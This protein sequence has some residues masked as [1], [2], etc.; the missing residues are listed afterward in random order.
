MKTFKFDR[1]EEMTSETRKAILDLITDVE[2][3]RSTSDNAEL[4]IN[5]L[6]GLFDGFFYTDTTKLAAEFSGHIYD[7]AN[8]IVD[9]VRNYK[10]RLSIN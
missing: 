1:H 8:R 4:L 7:E 9:T 3:E 10:L 6:F 5:N 2:Q